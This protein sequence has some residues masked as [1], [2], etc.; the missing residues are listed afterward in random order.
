MSEHASKQWKELRRAMIILG[1]EG[2][3]AEFCGAE[4]IEGPQARGFLG[5]AR[6]LS[7]DRS[8]SGSGDRSTLKSDR[9]RC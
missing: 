3:E 8:E 2:I 7:P 9:A 4:K 5:E 1:R 6:R